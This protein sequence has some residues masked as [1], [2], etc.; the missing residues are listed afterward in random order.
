MFS[1]A[2]L[3]HYVYRGKGVSLQTETP[4]TEILIRQRPPWTETTHGQRPPWT[5]TNWTQIFRGQ[6]PPWTET[7]LDRDPLPHSSGSRA[8][9]GAMAPPAL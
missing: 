5:E 7:A 6:R 3:I 8:A 2:C 9:Q 4:W 1:E